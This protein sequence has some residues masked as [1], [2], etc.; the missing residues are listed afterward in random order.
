ML[1]LRGE[2]VD[3][4]DNQHIVGTAAGLA[5]FHQGSSAGAGLVAQ[6]ADIPCAVTEK[7]QRL[8]ADAGEYQLAVLAVGKLLSGF[9][10]D[11]LRIEEILVDVHTG[12]L[13]AFEGNAG[14]GDFRQ[15]VNIISLN[16]QDF[17]DFPAHILAPGLGA[18]N[19]AAK[20]QG[21]GINAHIPHRFADVHGIGWGAAQEIGAVIPKDIHLALGISGGNR[22]GRGAQHLSAIVQP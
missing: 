16:I 12:L 13:F 21:F 2:H 6:L 18:E 7:R 17:F 10:I 14:S 1:H 9:R 11:D 8:L 4:A 22:D 5:H 19:A 3:A 20:L 15:A